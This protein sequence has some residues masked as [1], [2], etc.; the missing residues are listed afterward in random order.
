MTSESTADGTARADS[1]GYAGGA[2]AA[3][4]RQLV[5]AKL[6][7]TALLLAMGVVFVVCW[8]L[9]AAHPWLGYVRAAAEAGMVGALADWFAVTALFR[10]PLGVPIPHTAI[11]PRRKDAIGSALSEFVATHFVSEDVVR[12][13]LSRVGAAAKIGRFLADPRHAER[14]TAELAAALRGL[15]AV[16]SDEA[17]AD[18]LGTLARTALQR[19]DVG[20]PLGRVT[21]DV[22]RRGA[23]HLLVDFVIDRAHSW[24][25]DNREAV[26]AVVTAR[27]PGWSPRFVDALVADRVYHEVEA[28]AAAVKAD[29]QHPLRRAVDRFLLQ[30]ATDLRSDPTTRARA[31]DVVRRIAGNAPVRALASGAWTSGKLALEEAATDPDSALR[32]AATAGLVALGTRLADDSV[33]AAKVD[34]YLADAAGYLAAHHARSITGII[35]ETIARWDGAQT[36]RAIELHIGKDLQFIRVNGTVVGA[37]AGLAIYSVARAVLG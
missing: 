29:Q 37:L 10:H 11:I 27:A 22:V 31:N 20:P 8:L 28:F 32:R 5:R 18:V 14:A 23:H 1:A 17:V 16:L 2:A 3:R 24:I 26:T 6:F 25:R 12:Q 21:D 30:F 7:A 36:A 15:T 13:R 9:Q 35:D 19:T 4:R 33:T 34:A